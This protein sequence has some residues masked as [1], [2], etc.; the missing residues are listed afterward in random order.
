MRVRKLTKSRFSFQIVHSRFAGVETGAPVVE[1]F[2]GGQVA[3]GQLR[4]MRRQPHRQKQSLE[5]WINR[6]IL[7]DGSVARLDNISPFGEKNCPKIV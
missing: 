3:E 1:G 7:V 6:L 4:P 2:A 5:T